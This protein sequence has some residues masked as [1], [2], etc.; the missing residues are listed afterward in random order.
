M[1]N[2]D[3]VVNGRGHVC[4]GPSLQDDSRGTRGKEERR[5]SSLEK[6]TNT[7]TNLKHLAEQE[8]K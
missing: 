1:A 2:L 4:I 6:E 3:S 5:E 8:K 7:P